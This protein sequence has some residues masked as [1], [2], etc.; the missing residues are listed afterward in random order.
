MPEPRATA[1][2]RALVPAP[3]RRVVRR[4]KD[5]G[6]EAVLVGGCV[7][8]LL[9]GGAVLDYDVGTS[10]PPA[11]VLELFE[12]AIPTGIRHGTVMIPTEAGPVDVTTFR[13]GPRLEDD[14]AH[15]DFTVNALAWDP[16]SDR[17]VDPFGGCADLR[18]RRL[19]CVE[20]A[21][22]RFGEDPLRA[23][24]AARL[25]ATLGF[26][27]DKEIEAAMRRARNALTRVA[28]E[29][30]RREIEA[31]LAGPAVA[32]GLAL[33]RASGLEETLAPG[34]RADA[35]EIVGRLA[36]DLEPRL[37]GWLR[38]TDAGA[39][40][41]RWRFPR[42]RRDVVVR[43]LGRHPV[44]R[45][46]NPERPADLRRLLQRLG[47][48]GVDRLFALR[49]AELAAGSPEVGP[50]IA[51]LDALRET[52]E[53]VKRSGM[54]ALRRSDLAIDGR[55]VMRVLGR[56]PGPHVGEALRYLTE[57]VIEDPS[58]NSPERLRALLR[59]WSGA[60]EAEA[61]VRARNGRESSG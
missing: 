20:S 56:G 49:E 44:D 33:L 26:E 21:D 53:R 46:A 28:P 1:P 18:A 14:L 57:R 13:A 27:P 52:L 41:T 23:L 10:A 36:P 61:A 47:S 51:R 5:A 50:E 55:E 38:G 17:L 3:V 6:H 45:Y 22:A 48:D 9:L 15:R 29:R 42:R 34:V 58:V 16:E 32:R 4:L 30:V 25:V 39:V 37:A 54:L 31:L 35:P 59:E 60:L 11:T 19:R 2:P 8:D 40:L 12:R 43:L 24:R 7:R